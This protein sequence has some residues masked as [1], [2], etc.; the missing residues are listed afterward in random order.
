METAGIPDIDRF[1]PKGGGQPDPIMLA[2]VRD[3]NASADSR[4]ANAAKA[5]A[6]AMKTVAD[7]GHQIGEAQGYAEGA[8]ARI[9]A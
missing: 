8:A 3:I 4:T 6:Q 5:Q 9:L 1:L 7:L 2:K